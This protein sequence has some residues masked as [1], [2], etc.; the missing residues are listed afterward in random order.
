MAREKS[1][2]LSSQLLTRLADPEVISNIG[3]TLLG[4]TMAQC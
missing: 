1:H 3:P 2:R 4:A